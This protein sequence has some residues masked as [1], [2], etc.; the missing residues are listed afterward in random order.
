MALRSVSSM[1]CASGWSAAG[2]SSSAR[3]SSMKK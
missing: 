2:E 1:V 3:D